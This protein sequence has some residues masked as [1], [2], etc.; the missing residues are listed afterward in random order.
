M[1]FIKEWGLIAGVAG[2]GLGVF[3]VLF[4]EV[5][6]KK[7]F[8]LL[9]KKQGFQLIIIFMLL[10][11][12]IASFSLYI[13]FNQS[14]GQNGLEY[15][16]TSKKTSWDYKKS[17]FQKL[18]DLVGKISANSGNDETLRELKPQFDE[19]YEGSMIYAE[20][21][22]SELLKRMMILRKDYENTLEGKKDYYK[23]EKLKQSCQ[24]LIKQL[25]TT[26]SK[27]DLKN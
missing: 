23:P 3:L 7:I 13:Y 21:N 11:W 1:N 10:V 17:V 26:I 8:P 4:R 16:G 6:R 22:D 20:S 27:G 2:I 19:F 5:I 15:K 25:H 9:T 18:I 24:K 14:G 12:S